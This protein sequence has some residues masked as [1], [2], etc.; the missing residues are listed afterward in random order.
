MLMSY[1]LYLPDMLNPAAPSGGCPGSS[2]T[3]GCD[4]ECGRKYAWEAMIW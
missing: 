4:N 2:K 3:W 1:E